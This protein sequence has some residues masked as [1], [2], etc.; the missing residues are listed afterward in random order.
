VLRLAKASKTIQHVKEQVCTHIGR[1][2]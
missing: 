1:T 2:R